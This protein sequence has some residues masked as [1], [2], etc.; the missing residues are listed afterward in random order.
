MADSNSRPSW[1]TRLIHSGAQVPAGFRSLVPPVVRGS[2]VVFERYADTLDGGAGNN[3]HTYGL[4]GTPTTLELAARVAELE[5]AH[6]TVVVP[7]GQA[8]IALVFLALCRAGSHVLLP[9]SAYK[10]AA[11]FAGSL[12]VKLGVE[13]ETYPALIGAGVEA[14]I[15]PN[16]AVLW[17]ESPGS[18][19]MEVQDIP[20]LATAAHRHRVSVALDNTYAAGVL[21]DAFAH[22][23]DVSMQALT[24][25][26]GGHSDLLLGTVSV[27]DEAHRQRIA[28]THRLLGM[29]VSPDDCS[30][31]LRGMQTLGLRLDHLERVTLAVARWLAERPE[32]EA[33][34]HPALPGCPG[35]E[36]WRRDF[37]GSASVFSVVLRAELGRDY[38]VRFVDGLRLFRIGYS[39]GG[40]T[41]LV[42]AYEGVPRGEH[43]TGPRLVRLNVG[44][45]DMDD[46]LADMAQALDGARS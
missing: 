21:F 37:T 9:D 43:D 12:L 44:L 6:H 14:L 1:R 18:I 46:L 11:E 31:A 38:V 29:G 28:E 30:L 33:V 19:T 10:P 25:Y 34:L 32:V 23:V 16:T 20:A 3:G 41:S 36:T 39:W 4:Y 42:M 15:R 35:H 7:G 2:T 5:G 17:C 13:L 40:T 22:G 27:R 45:E 8:G 24:K 26:V